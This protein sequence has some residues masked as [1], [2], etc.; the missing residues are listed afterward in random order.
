MRRSSPSPAFLERSEIGRPLMAEAKTLELFALGDG[1]LETHL[2]PPDPIKASGLL[3]QL[4]LPSRILFPPVEIGYRTPIAQQ[5][6]VPVFSA[7]DAAVARFEA[8]N[9]PFHLV[10]G[11]W[12]ILPVVALDEMR[13]QVGEYVQQLC[14]AFLLKGTQGVIRQMLRHRLPPR[15][16]AVSDGFIAHHLSG[17]RPT[18]IQDMF[19]I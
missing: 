11:A 15:I 14:Q 19:H 6:A 13:P 3:D 18:A 16:K 5:V 2:P 1:S 4:I 17:L 9:A 10:V 7:T 12:E 8:T